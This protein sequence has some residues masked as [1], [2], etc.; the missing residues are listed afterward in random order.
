MSGYV[1]L[2]Q[3]IRP[4]QRIG[5]IGGSARRHRGDFDSQQTFLALWA[6]ESWLDPF[7]TAKHQPA[8]RN[9]FGATRSQHVGIGPYTPQKEMHFDGDIDDIQWHHK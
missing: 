1:R 3:C 7:F 5:G 2:Y 6:C 4:D 9:I 8:N